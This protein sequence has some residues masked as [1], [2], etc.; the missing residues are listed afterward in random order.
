M[1]DSIISFM[2]SMDM[3]ASLCTYPEGVAQVLF[4]FFLI[5]FFCFL[6]E[7]F[8]ALIAFICYLSLSKKISE[9]KTE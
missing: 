6:G 5:S 2:S 8:M 4:C 1:L 7:L 9:L 3:I